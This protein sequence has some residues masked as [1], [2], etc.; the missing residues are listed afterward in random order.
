MKKQEYIKLMACWVV[1]LMLH[2]LPIHAQRI[3]HNF[4]NTSMSEALTTLAKSTSDYRINFMYNELEDF[5]VTTQVVKRT[6]PEA[7]KQIIG[8]YPMKMTIDGKNIFVECTQKT[9]TKM[10][11]RVVDV[12]H[13]PVDFANISLLNVQDSSFITGGVTNENGQFV[14]PCEVRKAIVKVSCVGYQT[15]TRTFDTGKIGNI[16]LKE[17][18]MHLQKVVVK[19]SRPVVAIKGNALVTTVAN[20]QLEHAG[21]ANDVLRQIPMV[22]GRD[23]NFE[24]FGKGTPLIYINGRAVQDK[25]ELS[26]LNSQDIKNVEVITNPGAKYAASVKS[27]IR[28]R[29]KLP[30]GEGF[31]RTL[32]AQNGFRHYFSSME[33]A[34]LKYRTGGL[35]LFTNL[36]YY[37]GKFYSLE[38]MKMETQGST[39]WLQN[40]E[41]F[42]NMRNNE[43]FGKLGFSWM[44]N[45]HHSIGAYYMNGAALQ[46]PNSDYSSTSYADGE[47]DEEVSAVK[48][49]RKHTVPKHHA[50][51]YYNGEVGKLGIDFNMDY[52]W[53]KKRET[54]DQEETNRNQQQ[55]QVA[56]TSIGHSRMFAEKLVLSYPLWK[57][58]I[59]VGNEY[60]ASQMLND[61]HIN[62]ATIGNSNTKSDEK[63]MAGFFSIGQQLGKI[64]VEAGLRYEH[65]TFKYTENG[66]FKEDQS[67]TYNNVFPSLSISTEIGKT[68]WALSYTSKTQRPSYEDL[69]GTVTYVNRLL[70]GSGNPY[71]SPVKIHSVE[72][73]GAWKQFFAKVS[74]DY[75]KDAIINTSKPYGENGEMKYLTLENAPKT[76]ELQAFLG[77]QFHIGIWQ[78]KVN[79]GIIKQWFS[80]EYLGEHRSF[81]NPLG[82]VQFQNAI[83]LPGDIWMNIDMEWNSRGNKE[84]MQ[85]SSSSSL[86]AKLYKAFCKNR[87]SVTLEA[88]DIFNKS[89]RDILFYNKDVTLWQS[90]TSDSRSLYLTLQYNFNTSRSRYKG[91]GAGNEE[92]NRF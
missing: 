11:G 36:N 28:I 59:E 65:V 42:N 76:Q 45:E 50:N 61:F 92:L 81:G 55:K 51:I 18:T 56:S 23:G 35:E 8:F 60:I 7:I 32:R 77:A 5:T 1:L 48:R 73:M 62:M 34:N 43:F 31:G 83:H 40:I 64:A 74:Y 52:M 37:G 25:N 90:S 13:H 9:P 91:Q 19:S 86:N 89:N 30:Q 58:Q 15:Q 57:G 88:N 17:A 70:L 26:Q 54:S 33:Q 80:G 78:P 79:A 10:M 3:S 20:S 67:K 75:K 6:A 84:N 85:L 29:T 39:S 38:N 4:R 12:L 22:T 49:G 53:R 87:F 69:D 16:T 24:V 47:L 71:L 46:K 72:L 66:Q 82:I 14:I 63:N 27:V 68:Q 21:T 41:S 2:I 44:I